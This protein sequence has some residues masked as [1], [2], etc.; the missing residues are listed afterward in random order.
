MNVHSAHM[1][2]E[3][4]PLLVT[5]PLANRPFLVWAACGRWAGGGDIAGPAPAASAA[6]VGA[7]DRGLV[8]GGRG[9][10]ARALIVG[11]VE[12]VGQGTYRR[13]WYVLN[14]NVSVS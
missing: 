4:Q 10:A 6:P 14:R 9:G 12:M 1:R 13:L 11:T 5:N 3:R 2:A 8:A 7:G